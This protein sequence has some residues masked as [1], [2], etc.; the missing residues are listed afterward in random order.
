MIG[1]GTELFT[2]VSSLDHSRSH[3]VCSTPLSS[4]RTTSAS[5]G[6][7]P[8]VPLAVGP[9]PSRRTS[10][11]ESLSGTVSLEPAG[12]YHA[13]MAAS[14]EAT[15]S[16][17]GRRCGE[18]AVSGS[19]GEAAQNRDGGNR[20][21][22]GNAGARCGLRV[23]VR[24]SAEAAIDLEPSPRGAAADARSTTLQL[25]RARLGGGAG[26]LLLQYKHFF[27]K[28]TWVATLFP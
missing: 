11:C 26:G 24:I 8:A 13:N 15:K 10:E 7:L 20:R 6:T 27:M 17:D 16:A 9:A 2:H 1:S 3:C 5:D 21:P 23:R 25:Y 19:I 14:P 22:G 28:P 12:G 18:E 4:R